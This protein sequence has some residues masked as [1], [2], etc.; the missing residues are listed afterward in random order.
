M[1]AGCGSSRS[2]PEPILIGG[3]VVDGK[4]VVDEDLKRQIQAIR[5]QHRRL[6]K[7]STDEFTRLSR[8][9]AATR[10]N[11]QSQKNRRVLGISESSDPLDSRFSGFEPASLPG[12]A[13]LPPA[14]PLPPAPLPPAQRPELPPPVEFDPTRQR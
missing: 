3:S 6:Q 13:P 4:T 2:E 1:V 9:S 5:D 8:N 11:F 10:K 12:P 14:D 7:Q